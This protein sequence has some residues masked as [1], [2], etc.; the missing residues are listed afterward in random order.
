M[1]ALDVIS[2]CAPADGN[3]GIL[4]DNDGN[5]EVWDRREAGR[6]EAVNVHDKKINTIHVSWLVLQHAALLD[7]AGQLTTGTCSACV[8]KGSPWD[9]SVRAGNNVP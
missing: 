3:C 7:L 1:F 9:C 2:A 4:G 8:P 5:L 6:Q